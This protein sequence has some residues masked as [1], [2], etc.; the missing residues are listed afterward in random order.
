[1]SHSF[2]ISNRV[3]KTINALPEEER[4][5]ISDALASEL[6][7]GE[8]PMSGMSSLQAM[9]YSVVRYYIR[10]DTERACGDGASRQFESCSLSF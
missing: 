1:M 10:R 7:F 3:I 2:V 4:K 5:V 9:I 6:L 8:E